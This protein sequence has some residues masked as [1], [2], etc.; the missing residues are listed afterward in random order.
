M[1]VKYIAENTGV[2][3]YK[4]L[5]II[6]TYN[7]VHLIKANKQYTITYIDNKIIEYNDGENQIFSTFDYYALFSDDLEKLIEKFTCSLYD[8]YS[9]YP[10]VYENKIKTC[11]LIKDAINLLHSKYDVP[12]IIKTNEIVKIEESSLTSIND[13]YIISDTMP[14]KV[15][16]VRSNAYHLLIDSIGRKYY[17]N[18]NDIYFTENDAVLGQIE[19]KVKIYEMYMKEVIQINTLFDN[20]PKFIKTL[21]NEYKKLKYC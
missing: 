6:D 7:E 8:N 4:Y 12:E 2:N 9:S 1:S 18:I 10:Q 21:K 19:N 3:H 5:I 11:N 16:Y 20:T 14:C 17:R 13:Y 15:K